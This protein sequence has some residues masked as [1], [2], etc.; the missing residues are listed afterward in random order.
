MILLKRHARIVVAG[1]AVNRPTVSPIRKDGEQ[2]WSCG[3]PD[4][5]TATVAIG[6]TPEQAF[7]AWKE[8]IAKNPWVRAS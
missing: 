2:K 8:L 7:E 6:D 4:L 5:P 3:Y 1:A